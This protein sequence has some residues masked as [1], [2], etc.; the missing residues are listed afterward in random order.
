[1][2]EIFKNKFQ[3][4]LV[5]ELV[6][7]PI[8]AAE[9]KQPTALV[10]T[11]LTSPMKHNYQN[12]SKRSANVNKSRKSPLILRVITP[13]TRHAASPRLPARTHN[14]SPSNLSQDDLWDM[15]TANQAIAFGTKH[16][17]N[18][19]LANV[20]VHP[21]TGYKTE[22]MVLIKD[23]VLQPLWKRGFDNE[24]CRLFQGI[25]DIQ[26]TNTCFFIELKNIPK[27]SQITYGKHFCDYKL[28]N[29][30]K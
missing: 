27:S 2:T 19:H 16:L 18:F 23:P 22:Y 24:V 7:A 26:G 21:V 6:Q 1:L 10:Q 17:T 25:R 20:V 30:G 14:L 5:P 28:Q 12:M 3:K 11:I 9:N 29:K 4:P 15:E 13:V 8:K